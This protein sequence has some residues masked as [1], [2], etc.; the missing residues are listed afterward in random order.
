MKTQMPTPDPSQPVA[1]EAF[2]SALT[3]HQPALRGY[4]LASLGHGEEAKEALQRTNIVLWQKC[5]DWDPTTKFLRWATAVARYEVL[6]VI[7]D[8]GRERSRLMFDSDV[9]EQ[10]VD[11]AANVPDVGSERETALE[12]CLEK[13]SSNNRAILTAFYCDGHSIKEISKSENRGIS[14][15]KI[16]LMRVRRSLRQ[17][18]ETQMAKEATT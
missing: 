10:M 2:V 12:S 8:R 3:L 9:V 17:C 6:G 1:N 11:H 4:C 14:A 15:V 18:I 13:V 5:G 7:R 16:L